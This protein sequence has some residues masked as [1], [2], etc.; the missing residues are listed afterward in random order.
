[1]IEYYNLKL[2]ERTNFQN[3]RYTNILK[4]ICINTFN[5][6]KN[7]LENIIKE[8][9]KKSNSPIVLMRNLKSLLIK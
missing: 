8:N 4:N 1:L 7:D 6:D 9:I 2:E 3:S 5:Y